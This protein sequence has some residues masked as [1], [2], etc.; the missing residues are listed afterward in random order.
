ME[1]FDHTHYFQ[2]I[3]ESTL[4]ELLRDEGDRPRSIL[5]VADKHKLIEVFMQRAVA[6]SELCP[7]SIKIPLKALTEGEESGSNSRFVWGAI[8]PFYL[9]P[10]LSVGGTDGLS[11]TI[12][13]RILDFV[14]ELSSKQNMTR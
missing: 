12:R 7:P 9:Q 4:R 10:F 3:A 5:D 13:E 8:S 14:E 2:Q 1:K 11:Q 6:E